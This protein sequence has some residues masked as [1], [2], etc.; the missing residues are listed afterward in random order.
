MEVGGSKRERNRGRQRLEKEL[1]GR[2]SEGET[3]K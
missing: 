2:V 3:G 1:E